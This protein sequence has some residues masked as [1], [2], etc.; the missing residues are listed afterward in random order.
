M[1]AWPLSPG[2]APPFFDLAALAR[3]SPRLPPLDCYASA[4]AGR[5]AARSLLVLI[6][7]RS[8]R[9]PPRRSTAP[10]PRPLATPRARSLLV[11][12]SLRSPRLP[13]PSPPLGCSVSAAAGHSA[14]ALAFGFD[15]AALASPP[16]SPPAARLLR[17]RGRWP[18]RLR[19]RFRFRCRC[20]RPA[21]HLP[22]RRSTA[23]SPR[24]L[25]TP[26]ARSLL[27][28][29]LLRSPRLPPRSPP[30][31]CSVSA[32]AGHSAC[33]LAFGFDLAALASPPTSPPAARLLRLRGRWPL[34]LR[35]RPWLRSCC[36]RPA[37]HP[38]HPALDRSASAAA[39]RYAC[40]LAFG[41]DLA[42]LAPPPTSPPSARLLRFRG[43]W[44][45]RLRARFR[46]RSRC[47]REAIRQERSAP[48][49]TLP[50]GRRG[51]SAS[52]R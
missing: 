28:S 30:L 42:A 7:L 26:P 37:P 50:V 45:L 31:E 4:A 34:R 32:A 52:P 47:A 15:L 41:F 20:A 24:P 35:A 18:L 9:L 40:V 22:T 11:L 14:C 25:A 23:P 46:L 5:S 33:A 38:P 19:A 29:I 12:I 8:P 13:P 43:R 49:R 27:A 51:S 3:L 2:H 17:L 21:S 10:S 16:T 39:G 6:S 48:R 36:A 44:P 1:G